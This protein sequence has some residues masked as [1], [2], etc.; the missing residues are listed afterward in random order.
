MSRSRFGWLRALWAREPVII[1]TV[2]P[3]L[4]GLGLLSAAQ[5]DAV[6]A[7]VGQFGGLGAAAVAVL[8]AFGARRAVKSPA[9]LAKEQA[10]AAIVTAALQ[11]M[12]PPVAVSPQ[13]GTVADPATPQ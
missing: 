3:A 9:L 10:V 12:P 4:S 2:V 1:S 6:S 13:P 7:A 11:P 5:A 8:G